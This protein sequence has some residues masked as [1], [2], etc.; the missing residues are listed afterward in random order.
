MK[1]FKHSSNLNAHE[2]NNKKSGWS[3]LILSACLAFSVTALPATG[4]T[5]ITVA[6]SGLADG[7]LTFSG[8]GGAATAAQLASP[9]GLALDARGNLYFADRIVDRI[10]KVDVATGLISTVAGSGSR[11]YSGDGASATAAALKLP[12]GV[13]GDSQGNLY[14]ADTENDV[15]RKVDL[16][17][18]TIQTVAGGGNPSDTIQ[19]FAG[20][21]GPATEARLRKPT[22]VKVASN[23]DLYIAD[24]G[25][26]RVRKVTV[27]TAVISTV[28]GGS[29]TGSYA[30][31]QLATTAHLDVRDIVLDRNRN[32][33][34]A[35][36]S[37]N[38]IRR[39]DASTG[40]LTTVMGTGRSGG[41]GPW[42]AGDGGP[43]INAEAHTVS[44]LA[45]DAQN[46]IY[47][48]DLQNRRVRKVD[49]STGV[50][51]TVAGGLATDNM[52]NPSS[53]DVDHE[54]NL[55][56]ADT[57]SR[58]IRKMGL[59]TAP[60]I[61]SAAEL[62]NWAETKLPNLFPGSLAD[63]AG[64]GFVFRGPYATGNFMGVAGDTAYVLG[65]FTG[66]QLMPVG[67]LGN[68]TCS[69]KS[70]RC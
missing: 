15:V 24:S 54:G 5:S 17:T 13:A 4:Q 59:N 37:Q 16:L 29:L 3:P 63:Q 44:S 68:L 8:D 1:S 12:N 22:N 30:E 62:M 27:G 40:I 6:G 31:G 39:V 58:Q 26:G 57:G 46:N 35:L 25:H 43:A 45:I 67:T 28:A 47:F 69:V 38:R 50:I 23:G 19:S 51:S 20:D 11:G 32:L 65:P 53:V 70:L 18:G 34:I 64:S 41:V 33:Y 66:G 61:L 55:Y 49:S 60:P 48:V 14:I 7:P 52:F 21:G 56:I 10:R 36:G 2:R 42:F 9:T